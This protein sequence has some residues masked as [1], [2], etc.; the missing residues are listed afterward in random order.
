LAK[1][2]RVFYPK[3]LLKN[4][5]CLLILDLFYYVF[6]LNIVALTYERMET[7]TI[8][9]GEYH[10]YRSLFL[11]WIASAI[12]ATPSTFLVTYE[13]PEIGNIGNCKRVAFLD[14]VTADELLNV[15]LFMV[16][17]FVPTCYM[18]FGKLKN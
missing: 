11:I 10:V 18:M 7:V 3:F 12:G 6:G 1:K 14:S 9:F 13:Q 2:V 4:C 17:Y 15:G 8:T 16:Y 5:L